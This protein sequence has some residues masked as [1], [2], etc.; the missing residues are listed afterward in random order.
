MLRIFFI[1]DCNNEV[2]KKLNE[3]K[4]KQKTKTYMHSLCECVT[5]AK[6]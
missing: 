1:H 4:M 2:E 5:N 3:I 6:V